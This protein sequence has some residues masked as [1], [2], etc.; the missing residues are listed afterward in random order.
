MTIAVFVTSVLFGL[1]ILLKIKDFYQS[2][3][4]VLSGQQSILKPFMRL[5]F[6]RLMAKQQLTAKQLF[7]GVIIK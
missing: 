1:E 7:V 3:K 6:K 5:Y 4:R 2:S